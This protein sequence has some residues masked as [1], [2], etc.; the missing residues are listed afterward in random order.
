MTGR[1]NPLNTGIIFQKHAQ[2][3]LLLNT[4]T[5][6]KLIENIKLYSSLHEK[7]IQLL[8]NVVDRKIYKKNEIIFTEGKISNEIYFVTKGCIRLFDNVEG[9]DR[10]AFFYTE[11]KFI[12]AGESYTYN[13]PASEN[14]QAVEE[15]EIFFF[16]I[17][18]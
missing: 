6:E 11:G 5:Y 17:K 1:M 4:S 8:Q 3:A 16:E 14:Y 12:C 10:T 9:N 13:I 2:K 7:E 15:T 18:N